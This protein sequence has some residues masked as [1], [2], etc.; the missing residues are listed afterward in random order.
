MKTIKT[1]TVLCIPTL[2]FACTALKPVEKLSDKE[3]IDRYYAKDLELYMV[4]SSSEK[5]NTSDL[6]SRIEDHQT[7]QKGSSKIK[8]LE[9]RLEVMRQELLKRGYMP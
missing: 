2:L 8:K 5:G 1:I 6:S 7:K 4:K 3:L 9:Q